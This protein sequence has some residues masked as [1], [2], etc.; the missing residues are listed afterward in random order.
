MPEI[1]EYDP[2]EEWGDKPYCC[3]F[4]GFAWTRIS[5]TSYQQAWRPVRSPDLTAG[6]RFR[7]LGLPLFQSFPFKIFHHSPPRM[8]EELPQILFRRFIGSPSVKRFSCI[9]R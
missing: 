8:K 1:D 4:D 3:Y 5:R 6:S 7:S 9:A 2:L